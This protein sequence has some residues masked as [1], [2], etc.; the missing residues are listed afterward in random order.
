MKILDHIWPWSRI[1]HLERQ[2]DQ[3]SSWGQAAFNFGDSC[4]AYLDKVEPGVQHL[5]FNQNLYC[6]GVD[7][8]NEV[9]YVPNPRMNCKVEGF[10]S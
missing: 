1:R 8:C 9:I 5:R 10:D 4:L 6:M 3:T 2:V 7:Y